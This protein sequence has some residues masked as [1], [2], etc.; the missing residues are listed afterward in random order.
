[1]ISILNYG[2]NASLQLDLAPGVLVADCVAPAGMDSVET[3]TAAKA[4]TQTPID[5]PP[6]RQATVPGDHVVIALGPAVPHAAGVVAAIVPELLSGGATAEDVTILCT[7]DN[8]ESADQDPRHHL[9]QPWRDAVQLAKHD[10]AHQ[11]GLSYLTADAQGT[12]IYLNRL[13]CEADLVIPVGCLRLDDFI[14]SNGSPGVWNDT[15]YPTFADRTTLDHFAPNGVPLTTGQV[16]HHRRQVD[17]VAWL[18]GVQFTAQVV[19][20]ASETA[21]QILAGTPESVFREG[22][23]RCQ[24]A[25]RRAVPRRASL[26]VAGVGGGSSQLTWFQVGRALEAALRIVSDGGAI[27]LCTELA[28]KLGPALKLLAHSGDSETARSRLRKLRSADAPLAR[29][30]AESLDRATVYL[31]CRLPE[32][33]VSPLGFAHVGSPQEITRLATHHNSCILLPDAQFAWPTVAGEME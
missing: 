22:R 28:E 17:Q 5:F 24:A 1:M 14:H 4:V 2:V 16:A 13:L 32:D 18:L 9:P 25:W 7:Q 29:R 11:N 3:V 26:V 12:P 31:L 27:V 23:T 8:G 20:G 33:V 30:L 21:L 19:P 10:P 6:L 15:L